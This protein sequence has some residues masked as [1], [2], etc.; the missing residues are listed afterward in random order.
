MGRHREKSST[1]LTRLT[2][3]LSRKRWSTILPLSKSLG[4]PGPQTSLSAGSCIGS[5]DDRALT[6]P[7]LVVFELPNELTLCILS[8]ISPEPQLTGQY[9]RFRVQYG[10][11]IND[12]HEQRVRF[13][14]PLSMTC[15]AMRSRLLPWIW[16]QVEC[17][18]LAPR[19][20]SEEGTPR[21]LDTIMSTLCAD[22]SLATNVKYF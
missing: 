20:R 5:S 19:W 8:H 6:Y 1:L 11:D 12:H 2:Q 7:V 21:K 15:K 14:L 22:I 9:A 4:F 10:M 3:G 16:E 17:L 13:L 18:E